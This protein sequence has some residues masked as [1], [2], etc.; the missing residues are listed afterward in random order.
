MSHE[1]ELFSW[2]PF[3]YC[4]PPGR[5]F[6]IKSLALSAHVSPQTIHFWILLE[7]RFSSVRQE[8]AFGPWK[9]SPFLQQKESLT[10]H[11][12]NSW[13]QKWIRF[14]FLNQHFRQ[15]RVSLVEWELT[16]NILQWRMKGAAHDCD[17]WILIWNNDVCIPTFCYYFQSLFC[18]KRLS[19]LI[20]KLL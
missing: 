4:S 11:F 19:I 17:V 2:V 20:F 15:Q 13:I 1:A 3:P 9:G 10:V 16:P 7:F 12:M 8:P 5:P 18:W 14:I 6:P